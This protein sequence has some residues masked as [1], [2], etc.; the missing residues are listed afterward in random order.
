[1]KLNTK[2][3]ILVGFAFMSISAFWQMYDSVIQK[4][5][6]YDFGIGDTAVGAVMALDNILALFL[7][8]FFGMLSDRTR[9]KFGKRTPYIVFGTLSAVVLMGFLPVSIA[10]QSLL[11]FMVVL[12]LLLVA[13]STYR[14]PAVALMPDVTPKPLRSKGNAIINLMGSLGGVL[15]L[16]LTKL[17]LVTRE[18]GSEVYTNII[19]AVAIFMVVAVVIVVLTIRENRLSEETAAIND[20]YDGEPEKQAVAADHSKASLKAMDP[21]VRK[22]LFLILGSVFF[23]FMG[24]N[25]VTSA[26]SRFV[27]EQWGLGL[28]SASNLLLV[29]NAAAL[30]CFIPIGILSS[31]FG[32][33]RVIQFGVSLLALSFLAF[34]LYPSYNFSIYIILALVGVAWASINVNSYPMVVE[35]SKSGDVGQF[36]GYYYTFSMA[37]QAITPTVSG[38]LMEHIGYHTLAP[39]AAIMV[40]I[41]LITISLTK[42]GDSKPIP[43]K[44]KLEAYDAGDD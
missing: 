25:A 38:F 22:S 21:A 23:W 15:M 14:S 17:L 16:V 35:I 2:R 5:L 30:I 8:P 32:R 40:A 31:K 11:F 7:L 3:T 39:Y 20:A 42:H 19:Y 29:A 33:K 13:M 37:A 9:T 41:S 1:M 24:Y 36:T 27:Q 12:F 26:F 6:K 43:P 34:A 10:S 18:D 28:G 44:S 4:V